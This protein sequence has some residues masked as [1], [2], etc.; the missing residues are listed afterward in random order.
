MKTWGDEVFAQVGEL[1]SLIPARVNI[2][3]L[4]ATA[5]IE[6]MDIV[7]HRLC[8]KNPVIVALPP[9]RDNITYRM[10]TKV[11]LDMCCELSG[12]SPKQ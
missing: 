5:T 7:S 8:L 4:T 11:E 3:A 1:R 2:I 12:C 10:H 6:T 9:Y